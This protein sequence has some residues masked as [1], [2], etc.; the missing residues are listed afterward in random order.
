MISVLCY[1]L[2]CI[3]TTYLSSCENSEPAPFATNYTR[4]PYWQHVMES[5]AHSQIHK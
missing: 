5:Y 4:D 2:L 3:T 1:L